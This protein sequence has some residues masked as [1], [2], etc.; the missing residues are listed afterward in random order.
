MKKLIAFLLTLILTVSVLTACGGSDT[1]SVAE[2]PTD[3]KVLTDAMRAELK[4]EFEAVFT[5]RLFEGAAYVVYRGE[6]VYAGGA[7]KAIKKEDIPNSPDVVYQIGSVTKQFTAAAILRLCEEGKLSLDDTLGKYFPE[8]EAGRDITLHSMLSMQ[9]GIRDYLRSYDEN[10]NEVASSS[11]PYIEGIHDTY[12]AE[13]NRAALEKFIFSS[14]LLF[15]E[16]D[17][18]SYSNS[19]Y[20]LLGRI[21]EQITKMGC[22]EYIRTNFFEPLGMET[23]GFL[24][25]DPLDGVTLAKGYNGGNATSW[26]SYTGVA[27]ACGDII[28]SPKDLYKWTIALHSGRVL[29]K[30]MYQKMTSVHITDAATGIGYGYGLMIQQHTIGAK[31]VYHGGSIPGFISCVA[32]I[33]QQDY[34]IALISNYSNESTMTVTNKLTEIFTEKINQTA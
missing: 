3:A 31:I 27:F 7:G 19:N 28:A 30:E 29:G 14:E 8:Y 1:A 23:A 13:Q 16:G 17:R 25:D 6:E 32:Y 24:G 9:S 22:H 21:V 26:F 10:G 34:F 4:T 15:A 33:P 2:A 5:K 20:Y 12:T 11:T 18:Y